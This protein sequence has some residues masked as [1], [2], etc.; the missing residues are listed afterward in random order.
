MASE[1]PKFAILVTQ[2]EVDWLWKHFTNFPG[3][4]GEPPLQSFLGKIE[5]ATS[6]APPRGHWEWI[7]DA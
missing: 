4:P 6:S 7:R 3:F 5:P 1:S 2:E